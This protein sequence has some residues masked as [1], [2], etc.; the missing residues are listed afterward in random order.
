M[1]FVYKLT[2][3][4]V[5]LF[6]KIVL[7]PVKLLAKL[8]GNDAAAGMAGGFADSLTSSDGDTSSGSTTNRVDD[9]NTRASG[10]AETPGVSGTLSW[11][12]GFLSQ[13]PEL[14]IPALALGGARALLMGPATTPAEPDAALLGGSLAVMVGGFLVGGVVT[15]AVADPF[16]GRERGIRALTEATLPGIPYAIGIGVIGVLCAG[17]FGAL[18]GAF[19]VAGGPLA[20]VLVVPVL[21]LV[22]RFSMAFPAVFLSTRSITDALRESWQRSSGNVLTLAG[23]ALIVGLTGALALLGTPGVVAAT[24]FGTPFWMAGVTYLYVGAGGAVEPG[25]RPTTTTGGSGLDT[26]GSQSTGGEPAAWNQAA[27]DAGSRAA[28][29]EPDNTPTAT[30][31]SAGASGATASADS[32]G[33]AADDGASANA[34]GAALVES[35]GTTAEQPADGTAA[36]GGSTAADETAAVEEPT[37]TETGS[38]DAGSEPEAGADTAAGTTA[39][40]GEPAATETAAAAESVSERDVAAEPAADTDEDATAALPEDD[41]ERVAL[42]A[43]AVESGDASPD[44]L[45]ALVDALDASDPTVR[46]DAAEALGDLAVAEPGVAD[47]AIAALRECRLDPEVEVSE[48]ASAAL[49]RAKEG[50]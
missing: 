34:T 47:D 44:H 7:L 30:A 9:T 35:T 33:A 21:Y 14:F 18:F 11:V 26:G 17:V 6:V 27:D 10:G 25:G 24:T 12:W 41:A 46:R 16:R 4:F 43:A 50:Q 38:A 37:A 36:S 8:V 22:L 20:V 48:A 5:K 40:D 19:A 39:D 29:R 2:K 1:L 28:D 15:H 49:D 42:V 32:S 13:R 23:L 3:F 31:D 45:D